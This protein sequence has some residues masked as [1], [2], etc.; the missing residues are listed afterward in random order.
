MKPNTMNKI[1]KAVEHARAKHKFFAISPKGAL[2]LAMEELGE[3]AKAVND[4]LPWYE[5]EAE[6]L[7]TIAVLVRII[8]RD[9]VE[10]R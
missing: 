7:D 5:V 6:A 2:P 9:G 10:G 4:N 8:E 1:L 3:L